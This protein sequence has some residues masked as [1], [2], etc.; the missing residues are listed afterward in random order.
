M[1]F[2]P[3]A[4]NQTEIATLTPDPWPSALNA[5]LLGR[6]EVTN[7]SSWPGSGTTFTN[8]STGSEFSGLF[9]SAMTSSA[10]DTTNGVQFFG[11]TLGKGQGILL[12]ITGSYA[13]GSYTI[14]NAIVG[15]TNVWTHACVM[16]IS[17]SAPNDACHMN[18]WTDFED[19]DL[20]LMDK[21]NTR[22]TRTNS[23]FNTGT[24][25]GLTDTNV[26]KFY[27]AR[28]AIGT[29]G[30][31]FWKGTSQFAQS[32]ISGT[33]WGTT[34]EKAKRSAWCVGSN[35]NASITPNSM[36]RAVFQGAWFASY[37]WNRQLSDTEMADLQSYTNTYVKAN[38]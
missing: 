18:S 11:D 8:L 25:A 22:A 27:G 35:F 15:N 16:I 19:N 4:F 32:T 26:V 14:N 5:G 7:A 2:Q 29:N 36:N 28:V 21:G 9:A 37:I 31:R 13:S 3:F 17:S 38:S 33:T 1:R 10:I 30:N 6:W 24:V 12:G 20:W 34:Q 23:S